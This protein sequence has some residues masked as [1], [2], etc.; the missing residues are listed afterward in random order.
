MIQAF[1][2]IQMEQPPPPHTPH[3]RPPHPQPPSEIMK[4]KGKE[5]VSPTQQEED[6][7]FE[8]EAENSHLQKMLNQQVEKYTHDMVRIIQVCGSAPGVSLVCSFTHA[9]TAFV[10]ALYLSLHLSHSFLLCRLFIYSSYL[11]LSLF[12]MHFPATELVQLR[13]CYCCDA[14]SCSEGQSV[15]CAA[16]D[17]AIFQCRRQGKKRVHGSSGLWEWVRMKG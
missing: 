2:I 17:A 12:Y 15:T 13:P 7:R 4:V 16:F 14:G 6:V 11:S 9:W 3:S 10:C 1:C 8:L 5:P